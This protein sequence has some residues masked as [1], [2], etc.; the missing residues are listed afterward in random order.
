MHFRGQFYSCWSWFNLSQRVFPNVNHQLYITAQLTALDNPE[1]DGKSI[2]VNR[3]FSLTTE[4]A[5]HIVFSANE[6]ELVGDDIILDISIFADLLKIP[7]CLE[8]QYPSRRLPRRLPLFTP[9]HNQQLWNS[10]RVVRK[11]QGKWQSL[12]FLQVRKI[13]ITKTQR[14]SEEMLSENDSQTS[15]KWYQVLEGKNVVSR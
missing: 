15:R 9:N 11:K 12:D 8:K 1:S 3:T 4:T 14:T 7:W 10:R 5:T 13:R 2:L 6:T